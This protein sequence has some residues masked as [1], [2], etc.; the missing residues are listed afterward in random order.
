MAAGVL[1][2]LEAAEAA[3]GLDLVTLSDDELHDTLRRLDRHRRITEAAVVRVLGEVDVRRSHEPL[4]AKT[5]G[6]FAAWQ[7]PIPAET[8][9]A[10]ARCSR[11]LRTM[12]MAATSFADGEITVDHVR[13]LAACH[14]TNP[15]KFAEAE[16]LLVGFA[17]RFDFHDFTVAAKYW[18]NL[19]DPDGSLD[20]AERRFLARRAHV[21]PA[22]DGMILVDAQLDPVAGSIFLEMFRKLKRELFLLDWEAAKAIYGDDV[23]F[24]KLARTDAQRGADALELMAKRCAMVDGEVADKHG[25]RP[26]ITV[27]CGEETLANLCETEQGTILDPHELLPLL[28]DADVER[29]VFDT[30]SRVVDVGERQRF[31]TGATRRAVEVRD[32]ECDHPSCHEPVTDADIDHILEYGKDGLT[33]QANGRVLCKW[34]H[35]WRHR[36]HPPAA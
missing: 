19:A 10:Y 20:D 31:F 34:H 4:G 36:P 29:I 6:S 8:A 24:D 7:L 33:V 9:R 14:A 3:L 11:Q 15:E 23:S 28:K 1:D 5:L 30:P 25:P 21:G 26:L 13:V 16:E 18:R 27:L 12:P 2:K 35:R 22:S 32:R 17:L